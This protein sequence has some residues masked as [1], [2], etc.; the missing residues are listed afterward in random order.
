[1]NPKNFLTELKF[2]TKPRFALPTHVAAAAA[3]VVIATRLFYLSFAV[4]FEDFIVEST[5]NFYIKF[6]E[7]FLLE[8][9][10]FV[11]HL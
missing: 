6:T 3:V 8:I 5:A 1:V 4:C 9:S 11:V 2:H 10:K 7:E